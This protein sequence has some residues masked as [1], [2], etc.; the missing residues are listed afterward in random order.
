MV[1]LAG[2]QKEINN[3]HTTQNAASDKLISES[4]CANYENSSVATD[5]Y[6]LMLNITLNTYPVSPPNSRMFDYAGV[7]LWEA[8]RNGIRGG[9]SLHSQ[10][11]KMPLMPVPE[12]RCYLWPLAANAALADIFRDLF[13]T[14]T[15]A[16]LASMDSLEKAYNHKLNKN[17]E[18]TARSRAFGKAIAAS[19]F[20]WSKSDNADHVND[21]YTPPVFPGAWVPTPPIFLPAA[22]PYQGNVRPFLKKHLT[23][24][25]QIPYTYSKNP[26]SGYY[27]MV[28]QIYHQSKVNT[29]AQK[30][31]ALF[32]GD[33][34]GAGQGYTPPGH[35][36]SI[37]TQLIDKM[38]A[39]LSL[40][41]QL[42][43][44]AGI[45]QNDATIICFRSKYEDPRMRPITYI[46]S[47]IDPSWSSFLFTPPHPEFPAAHAFITPATFEAIASMLGKHFAFTDHTY[48]FNGLGPRSYPSL[49]S[50]AR[51]CGIS[52]FYGGIHYKLSIETSHDYGIAIGDDA[53]NV[54][55][56]R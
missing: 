38:H 37:L 6:K 2:C 39:S 20:N 56:I 15:N 46:D 35:E 45:A 8:V 16:N 36:M 51:E 29:D 53:A 28:K 3:K 43:V 4:I 32:W 21:P 22:V 25:Q 50:A 24:V 18:V 40:A 55:L 5:W 12:N 19:I 30:T 44:K 42:Y 41:A 54:Q 1:I 49:D 26:S 31:I 48:D 17:S 27:K 13:G 7:A 14:L 33:P 9:I 23:Q 10:L 47:F 34:N 52:R 11:Y